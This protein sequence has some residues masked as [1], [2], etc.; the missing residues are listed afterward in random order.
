MTKSTWNLTPLFKSDNDPAIASWRTEVKKA[1]DVFE[2]TWRKNQNYLTDSTTLHK[3]LVQYNQ[4]H[5]KYST[6]ERE[7]LYFQL[8]ET[9]NETDPKIKA[10][11]TQAINFAE[12]IANQLSFFAINLSKISPKQQQ[13]FLKDKSLSHYHHFLKRLFDEGKHTL[14]EKEEQIMMLKS[15]PARSNWLRLTSS[16]LATETVKTVGEDGKTT[17]ANLTQLMTLI[18]SQKPKVRDQAAHHLHAL[19]AKYAPIAENEINSVLQDHAIND[20]LRGYP[21]PDSSRLLGDDIT[22]ATVDA[23]LKAVSGQNKIAHSYY[24]LKAK[25]L[26]KKQLAYHERNIDLG[27]SKTKYPYE[28][29]CQL[30]TDTFRALDPEFAQIT[31]S[32][33][34]E[35]RIDVYPIK[36]KSGG[37]FCTHGSNTLPVYVMLNH[38]ERLQ[39]VLTMAHELGHGINHTLINQNQPAIYSHGSLATAEVASTFMEDFVLQQIATKL[40]A[41]DQLAIKMTK[42]NDDISTIFRQVACYRFEQDLH[43]EFR[44]TGY[45]DHQTIGKIFTKHMSAYMGPAVKQDIG[46]ENWWVYW[47]HIRNYF[48]VYSY[49]SG[50]LI[51]KALQRKVREN[52]AYIAKVKTFLSAGSSQSPEVIF[53]GLGLDIT[54]PRFWEEGIAEISQE[55]KEAIK[56]SSVK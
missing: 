35:G 38:T 18:S 3:A 14:T 56:L 37:A 51:S 17:E 8:R 10:K 4:F 15:Q 24:Q 11:L 25:L 46:S 1:A 43:T 19:M 13:L 53:K 47:S 12:T 26:G 23:M 28:T 41:K 29:A 9:Q 40:P 55:L 48:Y 7:I 39:D 20:Q 52:P 49:A 44:K 22:P 21:R 6:N 16:L 36:G 42:L 2:K 34:K 31:Q 33:I 45:L 50:L 27:S 54:N 32:F 5:T 30:V